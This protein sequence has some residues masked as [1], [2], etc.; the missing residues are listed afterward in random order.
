MTIRKCEDL[1]SNGYWHVSVHVKDSW[2]W[3]QQYDMSKEELLTAIIKPY[4]RWEEIFVH[5][6]RI[7]RADIA[8]I[9]ISHTNIPADSFGY[10]MNRDVQ[11]YRDLFNGA[12]NSVDYTTLLSREGLDTEFI[13]PVEH[14]ERLAKT[15]LESMIN[16]TQNQNQ[17]QNQITNIVLDNYQKLSEFTELYANVVKLMKQSKVSPDVLLD[18]IEAQD[19]LD[20]ITKTSELSDV[21]KALRKVNRVM[22]DVKDLLSNGSFIVGSLA[23]LMKVFNL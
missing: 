14:E 8:Q 17:Q 18:A 4:R 11:L 2:G 21:A 19:L 15:K 12:Q 16:V 13:S 5:G 10:V 7:N 6:H 1:P 20:S 9:K 3:T 22:R 23:S